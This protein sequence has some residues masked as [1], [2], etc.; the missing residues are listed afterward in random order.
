MA[1]IVYKC[2]VCDREIEK[3]QNKK[4]MEVIQRCTITDG[5]RG[6]LFKVK[7]KQDHIRGKFPESVSGLD[8][9]TQRGIL[10][11]H[12]QSI[13]KQHWRVIHNLGVEPSVQVYIERP[14]SET[15]VGYQEVTPES[16][17]IVNEN[18]LIVSFERGESGL[19]QC[20]ARSSKPV[21]TKVAEEKVVETGTTS[22]LTTSSE[23]TIATTDTT[24]NIQLKVTFLTPDGRVVDMF[25]TVDDVPSVKSP[26]AG[27]DQLF[28]KGKI[29][30]T[31]SFNLTFNETEFTD[32]TI[33]NGSA[34]FINTINGTPL[35][36]PSNRGRIFSLLT[37]PPF[38]LPDRNTEQLVDITKVSAANAASSLFYKDGEIYVYD[39]LIENVY[40]HIK[41]I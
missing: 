10:Y 37:D 29:Y 32:G 8:D 22:Q 4:G 11:N 3:V 35:S 21:L 17:E 13:S 9:W 7:E 12:V 1:V 6:K 26:W 15:E 39:S 20:V 25:Y 30:L 41:V 34:V 40:P 14:I 33:L 23:L 27:T 28:I 36:W 18:E 2:T 16:I 31:R 5:C 38:Q 19:V 24:Q